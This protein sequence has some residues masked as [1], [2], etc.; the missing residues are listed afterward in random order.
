MAD[1]APQHLRLVDT[2]TGELSEADSCPN[3]DEWKAQAEGA[4][5]EIRGWRTRFANLK[6]DKEQDARKSPQWPKAKKLFDH[7][8]QVCRHPRSKFTADRFWTIEPLLRHYGEDLCR[9]A[10]DGA[11][12]DPFV[13]TRR[14][15]TKA[16]H[17]D[18]GLIFRDAGKMES[19]ANRAPSLSQQ[20][21][22]ARGVAE[23]LEDLMARLKALSPNQKR[24]MRSYLD[25]MIPP[26]DDA[27]Q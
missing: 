17:D 6:A 5:V 20:M 21:T 19:F 22:V 23:D 11:A 2:E 3:C 26:E 14:N 12:F 15:G 27:E 24:T 10:I 16:R 9:K 18:W 13:T 8:R 4:Q 1:T 7:W 25:L